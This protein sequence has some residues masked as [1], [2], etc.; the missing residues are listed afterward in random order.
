MNVKENS[1][2]KGKRI[3]FLGSSVTL[4]ACSG[5]YSMADSIRDTD[6]AEV[7]KEAVNGTTL[8]TARD[9]SY[10]E[11]LLKIGKD[12]KFDLVVVQ[13]STNDA[14]A[15]EIELG[16]PEAKSEPDRYDTKTVFGAIG[17]ITD[18]CRKTW[19]CKVAFY[20]GTYFDNPKYLK[21]VEGL[22]KFA[23]KSGIAVIDLWNNEEMRKVSDEDYKVF[24]HDPV[25]P[26]RAGYVEWWTPV[27]EKELYKLFNV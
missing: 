11:R 16:I 9:N 8:S 14:N 26:T 19:G 20:T 7:T 27:I 17:F 4:G 13:L 23:K 21:M 25:H 12:Q 10:V 3:L 15:G 18:Y 6:G 2:L 22:L 1:P 24:M 5:E